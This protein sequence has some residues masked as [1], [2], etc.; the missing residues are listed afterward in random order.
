MVVIESHVSCYFV[1]FCFHCIAAQ[2]HESEAA[3]P[4]AEASEAE[5]TPGNGR[6]LPQT[7]DGPTSLPGT[8]PSSADAMSQLLAGFRQGDGARGS[9]A[10][11]LVAQL[12]QSGA[13]AQMLFD[14]I[15]ALPQVTLGSVWL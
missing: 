3:Q 13:S 8:T 5:P 4:V 2:S 14:A 15:S 1:T 6:H 12:S 9:T 11:D 7:G 10:A